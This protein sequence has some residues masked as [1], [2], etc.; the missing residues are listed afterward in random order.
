[1]ATAVETGSE[2][3]TP[4]PPLSLP[5]ASLLGAIYVLAA[6]AAVFYAVPLFWKDTIAPHLGG[7]SFVEVALRLVAQLAVAMALIW[8]G[9]RLLGENPPKGIHGGIFLIISS[10]ITVFF[11]WRALAMNVDGLPGMI[12]S[13]AFGLVLVYLVVRFCTGRNGQAWMVALEEQGWFSTAAYKRSLGVK[14]RRL[15]MLG[16][17][18]IGGSGVYSLTFQGILPDSWSLKMPFEWSPLT[19]VTDARYAV[20][21]LLLAA[22]LWVAFRAVN[23]PSFAEFLIATEAEMNKVSW[24]SKKRLGQDTVVVLT[25]TLILALFLLVV[26]L[27]WGWL[28]SLPRIGVLPTAPAGK[29]KGPQAE[30]ARW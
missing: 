16:I 26:D 19:V 3:R 15:T 29:A 5:I 12:V 1:M 23:I 27:F 13:T 28:L 8:F 18:L 22:T 17:L 25:T 20:P 21:L 9:R 6:I 2:P 11:L 7:F 24:T 14:V 4:S 10:A 30:K